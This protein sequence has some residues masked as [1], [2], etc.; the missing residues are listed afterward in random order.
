MDVLKLADD[1]S[2]RLASEAAGAEALTEITD[3]VQ[4]TAG[5][6]RVGLKISLPNV[7]DESTPKIFRVSRLISVKMRRRG[8]EMRLVLDGHS[9]LARKADPALLKA[10]ARARRWFEEITS[11]RVRSSAEIA[12]REALPKGYVAAV[13]RLAFLSPSLVDAVVEGRVPAGISLQKLVTRRIALPLS[14]SSQNEW[15]AA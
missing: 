8:V 12:R 9:D 6:L 5:G 1:L 2:R 7:A 4:L 13:M 11:G 3:K 10:L 15:L 14:W